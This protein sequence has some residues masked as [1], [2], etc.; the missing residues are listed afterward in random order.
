MENLLSQE[1]IDALMRALLPAGGDDLFQVK[2]GQV[3]PYDFRR[4]TKFKKDLLRTLVMIHDNFARLLQSVFMANLRTKAQ[5]H[6]RSTNQYSC[7]EFMQLLPNPSVA[8]AFRLD[9]LPGT[10]FLEMSHNIAF[11]IIDRVFGG[12]GNDVQPQRALSEIEK[13]VVQRMLSDMLRP[14]QE[15]WRNVAEVEPVLELLE[16]NPVFLQ[17]TASSEV[18]AAVTLA[19]EIGEHMGHLTLALPHTMIEPLLARLT[20]RGLMGNPDGP[21]LPPE[22]LERSL[23]EAPVLV[24][25]LLGNIRITVAEFSSLKIGDIISLNTKVDGDVTV[26]VGGRPTFIG[27]P[28]VTGGRFSVQIKRHAPPVIR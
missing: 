10:C 7:S 14:L 20:G 16:T 12:S 15:A 11:A 28:G 27:R 9:P 1:E 8:A 6:V 2:N 23:G 21:L 3:R 24:E 18:V 22:Q 13:G 5:I 19:I 25:A 17:N 26:R 4:P